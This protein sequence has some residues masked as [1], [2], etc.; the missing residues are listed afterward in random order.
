MLHQQEQIHV[1]RAV[2]KLRSHASSKGDDPEEVEANGFAAE[3]LMPIEFLKNDV[4][5]MPATDL[6]DDRRMQLLAK[7]YQVSV[8]AMTN[9]LVSLGFLPELSE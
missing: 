5:Q 1:D 2:V 6:H 3:L 8:V 7:K 4:E 9:R